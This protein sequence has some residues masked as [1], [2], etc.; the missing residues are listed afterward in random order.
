VPGAPKPLARDRVEAAKSIVMLE[1]A[2]L[3]AEI[4]NGAY[5]K[6]M[7]REIHYEPLP[8]EVRAVVIVSWKRGGCCRRWRLSRWLPAEA[9]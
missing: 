6:G 5:K 7:A 1:V 4:A 9:T 2:I 8:D 3:N